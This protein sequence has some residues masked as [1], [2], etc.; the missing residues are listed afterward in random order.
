MSDSAIVT[1]LRMLLKDENLIKEYI[2]QYGE[3]IDI[4]KIK[5]MKEQHEQNSLVDELK[6]LDITPLE[7]TE[8][9]SIGEDPIYENLLICPVC[10]NRKVTS[11]NLRAKS[12]FVTENHFLV[13]IY[14][15]I[16]KY[17]KVNFTKLGTT[18]CPQCLFASPDPKDF[19]KFVEYTEKTVNSQLLVHS[20]LLF[21][22]EDSTTDRF[23]FIKENGMNTPD[24]K[25]PRSVK[26]A[27]LSIKL[28]ILRA[29]CEGEH[30]LQNTLFK[31]GSYYLKIAQL[32]KESSIDNL[33]TLQTA[34]T[35]FER[36][37]LESDCNSFDIEMQSI[38]LAIAINIKLKNK[39]KMAAFFKIIK[40][41]EI[42]VN[43]ELKENPSLL[44]YKK[45]H[46]TMEKWEK[47]SK[48]A[49][50]YRDDEQYWESV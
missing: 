30:D 23:E 50:E 25:R 14:D 45:K 27:I 48:T 33:E 5:I 2:K 38:Y 37:V 6:D 47:R 32:E 22:M 26:N 1:R 42:E 19:S 10:K 29:E 24:F 9:V 16:G 15:G 17:R 7:Q 41:V 36:A 12:Q 49:M 34:A 21:A 8:D 18:V 35:Y 11:Y 4:S 46:A 31:I 39:E 44:K 13:P 40:D 28:S 20:R 43:E 3:V